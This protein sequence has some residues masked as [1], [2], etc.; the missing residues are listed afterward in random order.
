[1][2]IMSNNRVQ[3][4][5]PYCSIYGWVVCSLSHTAAFKQAGFWAAAAETNRRNWFW[6]KKMVLAIAVY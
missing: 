1:M 6:K 5:A 2:R 3:N 4:F